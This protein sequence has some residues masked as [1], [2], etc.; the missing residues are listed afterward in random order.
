MRLNKN[1]M[2]ERIKD[3]MMDTLR[4]EFIETDEPTMEMRMPV[5][6]F[7]CQTMGVLH[8]GAT[9]ALAETASGVGSNL[10]CRED[11]ECYGIQI[12]ASHISSAKL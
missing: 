5:G 9:V 8:G 4:M 7:N 10:L 2:E 1:N 12:S 6:R 11:E 3:T